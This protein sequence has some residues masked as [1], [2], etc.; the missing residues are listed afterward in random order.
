[1]TLDSLKRFTIAALMC[2][3]ATLAPA[4]E[5]AIAPVSVEISADTLAG[6]SPYDG[7]P[8][9]GVPPQP[10]E[11]AR[12]DE[13][14][15]A[16][17]EWINAA[18]AGYDYRTCAHCRAGWPQCIREHATPSNT[19]HYCG[20]YVGGGAAWWGEGY[21]LHEGTY[22]WDYFGVTRRK[23]VS[24]GWWHGKHQGGTG[25]YATDGPKVLHHE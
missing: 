25:R 24:L 16:Q 22:G 1:M 12:R 3:V 8:D 4:D 15:P 5:P 14:H 13:I 18:Y 17:A 7:L 23:R 21:F 2:L 9:R 19:P 20:Y 11:A 10:D 6:R